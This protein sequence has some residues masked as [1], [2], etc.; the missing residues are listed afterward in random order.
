[1]VQDQLIVAKDGR[2]NPPSLRQTGPDVL[3]Q[4]KTIQVLLASESELVIHL[5]KSIYRFGSILSFSLC[6][7]EIV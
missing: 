2:H 4:F 1:M 7:F 5:T 3:Q 6:Y